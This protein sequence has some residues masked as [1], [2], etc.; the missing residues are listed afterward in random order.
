MSHCSRNFDRYFI[1]CIFSFVS[2]VMYL[3]IHSVILFAIGMKD[4]SLL[5]MST[6]C[7]LLD[8]SMM[9]SLYRFLHPPLASLSNP[10]A[11]VT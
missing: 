7:P 1:L 4:P 3:G 6:P 11:N 10:I 8:S 2:I 5:P 9:P